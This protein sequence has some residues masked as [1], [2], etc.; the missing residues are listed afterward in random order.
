MDT[1]ELELVHPQLQVCCI[2][3]VGTLGYLCCFLCTQLN[4]FGVEPSGPWD[5]G[6]NIVLS[7]SF[8]HVMVGQKL[9]FESLGLKFS[10]FSPSPAMLPMMY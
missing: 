3:L 6:D 10:N 2:T 5:G 1:V 9:S 7:I 8:S 4:N